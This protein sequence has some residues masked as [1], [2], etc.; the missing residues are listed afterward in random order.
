MK[1]H[2]KREKEFRYFLFYKPYGVLC[3]FTDETGRDTLANYGPFPKD[4]YPVGRLDYDSEGL[5][6]L[7][8]NASLKQ[9]L[10]DPQNKH[11]RTYLVQVENT[12]DSKQLEQLCNGV[13]IGGYKTRPAKA[14]LLDIE[15]ELPPRPVPIRFRKLIPTAWLEITMYEGKNRQ[16]RRMTAAVGLPTL[17][18]VRIKIGEL[19]LNGLSPGEKKEV[20]HGDIEKLF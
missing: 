2:Q 3:Q 1:K 4:V 17:R 7:S 16:V 20:S 8:N 13:I 10:R 11:P 6:L 19:T 18:L 5:V 14:R 15:P 9:L 12:P